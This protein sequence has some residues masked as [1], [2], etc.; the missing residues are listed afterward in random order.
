MGY[1][2]VVIGYL[3]VAVFVVT[4]G[5]IAALLVLVALHRRE[6]A[7]MDEITIGRP[8]VIDNFLYQGMRATNYGFACTFDVAARRT[9][10]DVDFSQL[11]DELKRPFRWMCKLLLIALFGTLAGGIW[12]QFM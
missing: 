9:H 6:I 8:V 4:I 10:P 2:A 1:P 12:T 5:S 7:R 11:P 3:F